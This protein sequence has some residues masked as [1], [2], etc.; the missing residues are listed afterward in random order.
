MFP[1]FD[2]TYDD[3]CLIE[4]YEILD[5]PLL[6]HSINQQGLLEVGFTGPLQTGT[7]HFRVK[8]TVNGGY[9][10][11]FGGLTFEPYCFNSNK[12]IE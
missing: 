7:K 5:E 8:L 1:K 10:Q 3:S 2:Y 9:T 4:Q 12:V 6:T 11:I